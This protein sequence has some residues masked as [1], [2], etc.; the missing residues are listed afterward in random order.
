VLASLPWSQSSEDIDVA[1]TVPEW[2]EAA[3]CRGLEPEEA[4][5]CF[6]PESGQSAAKGREL[7]VGVW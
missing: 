2:V 7:C 4:D 3:A 6:F 1:L 5:A